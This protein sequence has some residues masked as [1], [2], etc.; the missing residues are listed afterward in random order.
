MALAARMIHLTALRLLHRVVR[1]RAAAR[2][3]CPKM[4]HVLARAIVC[5][6]VH[7]HAERVDGVVGVVVAGE[8][9]F[10]APAAVVIAGGGGGAAVIGGAAIAAA[11]G[12][13]HVSVGG[14]TGRCPNSAHANPLVCLSERWKG[15]NTKESTSCKMVVRKQAWIAQGLTDTVKIRRMKLLSDLTYRL[16]SYSCLPI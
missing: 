16:P 15:R 5:G 12:E 13:L 6:Y 7:G 3:T 8:D 9:D 4:E 1:H 14:K 10:G 2:Q 11:V